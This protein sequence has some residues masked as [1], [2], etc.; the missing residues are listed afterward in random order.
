MPL[1]NEPTS[2]N[3]ASI[4]EKAPTH[5]NPSFSVFL[6]TKLA[7]RRE[8]EDCSEPGAKVGFMQSMAEDA[9]KGTE[10]GQGALNGAGPKRQV[11][12]L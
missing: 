7:T 2:L 12:F 9:V 8:A 5:Y 6:A 4:P 10:A 3:K 11:F 1:V